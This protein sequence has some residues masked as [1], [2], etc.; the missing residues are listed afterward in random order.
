MSS[1]LYEKLQSQIHN[2]EQI[3]ADSKTAQLRLE[4]CFNNGRQGSTAS[5][6]TPIKSSSYLSRLG[7]SANVGQPTT[8]SHV[9]Q[10]FAKIDEAALRRSLREVYF[11]ALLYLGEFLRNFL[12]VP[13]QFISPT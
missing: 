13:R 3:L 6:P 12:W 11:L 2:L 9:S 1:E 4:A 8:I 5:H 10:G 7:H